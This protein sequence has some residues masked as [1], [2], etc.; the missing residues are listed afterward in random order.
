ML[1]IAAAVVALSVV[2]AFAPMTYPGDIWRQSDTATIARN[3]AV[4]G[5]NIFFPQINWGG[6]GPGYV[7]TEFQLLPWL[8][9]VTY[10]IFGEHV[11]LGRLISLTFMLI[12]AAAFWGVARRVLP[13][14]AARW[15][16]AAFFLSPAFMRWGT[17]FM[18]E[19][20]VLAFYL[21]ALL[22]FLRW[23]REDRP[24]FL[25]WAAAATSVAA[26]V[27][28]TSLHLGL[29]IGLWVVFAARDRLRRPS[30]YLA[31]V[32]ALVAPALWLRHAASLHAT[33]GNTFGVISGGDSKWG[34]LSLWLSPAFYLG[35]LR[36]ETIFV[37]G[38]V[39]LPLAVLGVV[40]LWRHRSLVSPARTAPL[41]L[42]GAA[43]VALTIYYFAAGR[44]TSS[45]LGIQY[46]VY[47]LPYAALA[48]GAG[49]AACLRWAQARIAPA[50]T[51]VA[52]ALTAVLLGAQSVNVFVQSLPD[53]AG[54]FGTCATE[55]DAVSAPDDLVVVS[56][57]SRTVEDGVTN[58]YQEP[59]VFF[60]AD[61][62]GWSLA[63]DNHTPD[64]VDILRAAGA[65]FLVVGD[66]ELVP[67]GSPLA[68]W[69]ADNTRQLRSTEQDGCAIWDLTQQP[70]VPSP[71]PGGAGGERGAS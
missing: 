12:A 3:F 67:P 66:P 18:P 31:G 34:S 42:L 43:A 4:N 14:I 59:V 51:T 62:K 16:L 56:T 20:T 48:V 21:L 46:H 5:M 35:N 30:L 26:L 68:G 25:V 70:A 9:A 57:T 27:K 36:T 41:P 58:N 29:V 15:A 71:A 39:G 40:W 63:A 50:I 47:S 44:Y 7:E 23:L 61:R 8:T 60:L 64:N 53:Q 13:S 38:L 2:R 54:V 11:V 17:A 19:A 69:L 22:G 32:A 55:L 10:L 37:Y 65:R 49:V 52:G 6:A 28:P 1:A 45:D 33:Y 24:V